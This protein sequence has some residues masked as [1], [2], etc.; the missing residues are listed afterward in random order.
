[1]QDTVVAKQDTSRIC[2][3]FNE[4][5]RSNRYRGKGKPFM[6]VDIDKVFTI[7]QLLDY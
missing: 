3:F 4:I 5:C 2:I 7:I 1:M 6:V